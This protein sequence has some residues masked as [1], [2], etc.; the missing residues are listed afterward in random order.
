TP[1]AGLV[2]VAELMTQTQN[3]NVGI[4]FQKNSYPH[5]L[6]K[7]TRHWA[8]TRIMTSFSLTCLA[9]EQFILPPIFAVFKQHH[10]LDEPH[11]FLHPAI[12]KDG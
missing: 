2:R 10:R 3:K 12:Q 9:N 6:W 11:K 5:F 4:N 1:A 7:T 8:Q